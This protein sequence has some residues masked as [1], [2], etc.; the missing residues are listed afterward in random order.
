VYENIGAAAIYGPPDLGF[1]ATGIIAEGA[2]NQAGWV[3][4]D[5]ERDAIAKVRREGSVLNH[6]HWPESANRAAEITSRADLP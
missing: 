4:A 1:P 3:F 5:I 6:A 2:M